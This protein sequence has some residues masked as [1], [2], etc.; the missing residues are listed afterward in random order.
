MMMAMMMVVTMAVTVRPVGTGST[1]EDAAQDQC[2]NDRHAENDALH[3]NRPFPETDR[4]GGRCDSQVAITDQPNRIRCASP[5]VV[6]RKLL[7]QNAL[8]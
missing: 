4:C 6:R 2:E 5:R 3:D 7:L 8:E 1:G